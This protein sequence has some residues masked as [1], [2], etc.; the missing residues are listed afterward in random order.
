MTKDAEKIIQAA[1][2]KMQSMLKSVYDY[3][4]KFI[5]NEEQEKLL[6]RILFEMTKV[7][8]KYFYEKEEE[9]YSDVALPIGKGQTISQPSTVAR[10]LILADIHEGEDVLEVGTGSGWNASLI[11]F[12]NYPGNTVSVERIYALIEKA[13]KNIAALRSY[14]KQKHPQDVNNLDKLNLYAENIFEKGRAW[15]KTYDKIILT[16]G[17]EKGKE[18]KVKK[19]AQKLLKKNGVMICPYTEGPILILKKIDGKLLESTTKEEYSFVPLLEKG[20]VK[21]EK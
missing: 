19:L 21:K 12:L 3:N 5:L 9:V 7:D 13:E 14:L 2:Q 1:P 20:V 11:S 8:R 17:I 4:I 6:S 10:M 15:K 18:E 16:A